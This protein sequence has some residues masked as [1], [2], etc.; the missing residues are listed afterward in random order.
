M[1]AR[2][3]RRARSALLSDDGQV[4]LEDLSRVLPGGLTLTAPRHA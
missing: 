3:V 2:R 1:H 4:L